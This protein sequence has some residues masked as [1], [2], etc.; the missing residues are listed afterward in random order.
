MARC[1]W[2]GDEFKPRSKIHKYCKRDCQMAVHRPRYNIKRAQLAR[3]TRAQK[4]NP[5]HAKRL[6]DL[7]REQGQPSIREIIES[8]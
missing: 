2:C 6:D 5:I 7:L 4:T 8:S 1:E 3:I